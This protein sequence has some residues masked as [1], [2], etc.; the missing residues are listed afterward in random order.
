M[1]PTTWIRLVVVVGALQLSALVS[2]PAA[3]QETTAQTAFSSL[4]PDGN[5][6]AALRQAHSIRFDGTVSAAIRL[7]A[8]TAGIDISFDESLPGLS[9]RVTLSGSRESTA[10]LLLRI[11]DN[12][13]LVVRVSRSGQIVVVARQDQKP[14]K[15]S[16]AGHV[17]DAATGEP[18]GDVRI[19][20]ST[21]SM[22]ALSHGDGAFTIGN[23]SAGNHSLH[24]LR[25]GYRPKIVQVSADDSPE[26]LVVTLEQAAVALASVRVSPG[27]F[28][29]MEQSAG[30]PHS[31]S[32]EEIRTNP[33]LDEDVFR[34]VNKL[35]GLSA[36]DLS[37]RFYVRG[38][39]G[40]ELFVSLD[41]VE[42]Y[43]PFHLKDVDAALSIVDVESIGGIDLSTGGFGA[44]YG[45]RLTGVFRMTSIQPPA[46]GARHAVGLSVTNLR[47]M[48]QGGFAGG[49]GGWVASARRGYLDLALRLTNADDSIK[50]RYYDAFA[51]VHYD[52]GSNQR[53]A[54]HVLHAGDKM[55]YLS[56]DDP[57]IFSGYGSSYG[58]ITWDA[59]IGSRL[60][61]AT[62]AS[63]SKLTWDRQGNQN[64][65]N[66]QQ[67]LSIDDRRSFNATALRQDFK[68]SLSD[69][70]LL[71]FGG[72]VKHQ[73]AQYDYLS[74]FRRTSLE[75]GRQVTS[76]DSC[77]LNTSPSGNQLGAYA[78]QR[79]ALSRFIFEAGVRYDR[80][81]HDERESQLSPRLSAAW[82]ASS[83]TTIRAAWGHYFQAQPLFELQTQD[84]LTDFAS[85]ELA[86]HRVFGIE[87]NLPFG[88]EGRLE[89]YQ[90]LLS[91]QRT[92]FVN[93]LNSLEV[94]PE[95]NSDR[96]RIDPGNGESRGIEILFRPSSRRSFDWSATYALAS[97]EDEIG[98]RTI[99][100]SIDQ[101]HTFSADASY[102]AP[103]GKW[104]VSAGLLYH[105]GWPYTPNYF[106][107][108]TIIANEN[109]LLLNITDRLGELNS[110]RLP[111][112]YRLDFRAT[113]Y[114][115]V[116]G[117]RIAVFADIFNALNRENP[118][119]YGYDLKFNPVRIVRV[120]DTQVPRLPTIGVTW[121]F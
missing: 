37:A 43:E 21:E 68:W 83:G 87:Q 9:S 50:P 63:V 15:V 94:F 62:V 18:I 29:V 99:P 12:S 5:G 55:R 45:D 105:S 53:V 20:V 73:S 7:V 75:D 48:S 104:R 1:T 114:L 25:I 65:Q 24:F 4:R 64:D 70:A 14:G 101:R 82:N 117:T 42:L 10:R 89:A 61:S 23:L 120:L 59:G 47:G 93:A 17:R 88:I 3:A 116:R 34:A 11:V 76:F 54:A 77:T 109:G 112:Y 46:E 85:A 30:T 36:N 66:N 41:G 110:G 26:R 74:W 100:R 51:K 78:A 107:T 92:R 32:R 106:R 33:Q 19:E 31:L 72:E 57:S 27:Q 6:I 90:R 115:S 69:R 56:A 60:S 79:V 121:E 71:R 52:L 96:I 111:S 108:D 86:E 67:V 22:R 113:R 118:R 39:A 40:D 38:G 49:R 81:T 44:E 97:I 98:G 91:R 8:Q 119:G 2:P 13:P 28:G 58:W 84:G 103:S 95:I 35:P 102:R 16:I 80:Q